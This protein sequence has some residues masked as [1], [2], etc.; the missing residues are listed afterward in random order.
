MINTVSFL[1]HHIQSEYLR[2]R[3]CKDQEDNNQNK[4]SRSESPVFIS[5]SEDDFNPQSPESLNAILLHCNIDN[6]DDSLINNNNNTM[7]VKRVNEN[8]C[9]F[10]TEY[11]VLKPPNID[12][13][14]ITDEIIKVNEENDDNVENNKTTSL[15]N[16][17]DKILKNENIIYLDEN[18]KNIR[19][20]HIDNKIIILPFINKNIKYCTVN[21]NDLLLD[22]K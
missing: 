18:S 19:T 7:F 8:N 1:S 13:N 10:G 9:I 21:I 5:T 15:L 11:K 16:V 2:K 17:E 22:N 20:K 4:R 14:N 6:I 12:I 3:K